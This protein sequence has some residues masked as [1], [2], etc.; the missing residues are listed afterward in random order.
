MLFIFLADHILVAKFI[1][2]LFTDENNQYI[3]VLNIFMFL[4]SYVIFMVFSSEYK[5]KINSPAKRKNLFFP[6]TN[7]KENAEV[8]RKW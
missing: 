8:I 3:F 1:F 7:V 4:C 5:Q 6:M 2:Y